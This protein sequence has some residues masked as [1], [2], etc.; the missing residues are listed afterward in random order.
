MLQNLLLFAKFTV[1]MG[2]CV[3]AVF[4]GFKS[5]IQDDDFRWITFLVFDHSFWWMFFRC[6]VEVVQILCQRI[7]DWIVKAKAK[8][9]DHVPTNRS[10]WD[11][12]N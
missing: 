11:N 7:K 5:L 3:I 8:S 4:D 1:V 6:G 9:R 2:G 12:N 10:E